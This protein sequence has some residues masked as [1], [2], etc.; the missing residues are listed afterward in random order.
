MKLTKKKPRGKPF[1][2]KDDP[3]NR[4]NVVLAQ[5]AKPGAPPGANDTPDPF[6]EG[7]LVYADMR[8]VYT[9]PKGE[10]RTPA[11]KNCRRW[12]EEDPKA[13]LA[14]LADLE[15]AVL[16]REGKEGGQ[17]RGPDG[18]LR[19]AGAERVEELCL[20][21]LEEAGAFIDLEPGDRNLLM[22]RGLVGGE[23]DD[24]WKLTA[25]GRRALGLPAVAKN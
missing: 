17:E 15:R 18:L 23:G 19:D 1:T 24:R 21:L 22:Q 16:S 7:V 11:Q 14:K 10:D 25:E 8:H 9:R 12:L 3:R 5:E 6:D 4:Q 13:F 20:S 2:G